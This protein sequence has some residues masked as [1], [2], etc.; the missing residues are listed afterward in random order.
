[1]F[2]EYCS[3]CVLGKI[4]FKELRRGGKI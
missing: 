4:M 1:M 2:K 3:M